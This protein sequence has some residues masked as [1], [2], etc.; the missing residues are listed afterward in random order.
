MTSWLVFLLPSLSSLEAALN[1]VILLRY[2]SGHG[3]SAP[4]PPVAF[5]CIRV[6]AIVFTKPYKM[7]ISRLSDSS[8]PTLP[9]AHPA[10]ATVASLLVHLWAFPLP[11]T[12]FPAWPHGSRLYSFKSLPK[13]QSFVFGFF[14][15]SLLEYNCFTI[16]C[17]FLLYNKVNQPYAYICPHI[18]SLLSLP[19]TLPIPPYNHYGK[20]YGS[21]LKN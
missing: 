17:K 20:Q 6:R 21:S 19:S 5:H 10:P 18:P 13:Y 2:K 8:P 15:R 9:L 14:N 1:T 3:C 12:V 16:L 7:H 11:T 4:N